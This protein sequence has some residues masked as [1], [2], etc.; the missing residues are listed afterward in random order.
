MTTED[1]SREIFEA[2]RVLFRSIGHVSFGYQ[3][4]AHAHFGILD[5]HIAI[6]AWA[7]FIANKARKT[8]EGLYYDVLHLIVDSLFVKKQRAACQYMKLKEEIEQVTDRK[9]TR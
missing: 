1:K 5:G 2:R 3:G 9:S 4:H 6:C 7:R 8:A